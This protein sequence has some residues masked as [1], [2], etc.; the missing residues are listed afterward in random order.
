MAGKGLFA[1]D[2]KKGTW[3]MQDI[4]QSLAKA[5]T[6]ERFY[7]CLSR[8]SGQ[9]VTLAPEWLSRPVPGAGGD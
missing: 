3:M 4:G 7:H 8:R 1:Q 9:L 6:A 2:I 5:A